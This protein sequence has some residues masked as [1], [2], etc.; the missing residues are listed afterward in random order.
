MKRDGEN[1]SLWQDVQMPSSKPMNEDKNYDVIIAGAGISGITAGYLLQKSGKKCLIIE[2]DNIGFGTTGGTTAHINTFYDA[3]YD[4]VI[5]DFGEEN[6]QL[7]AQTGPEVINQ[8]KSIIAEHHIDCEF[9]DRDSYIFSLDKDQTKKLDDLFEATQKVGI[10]TERISSNPFPIPFD[11]IIKIKDQAQ[12]HP[13]KYIEA[14]S[15]EFLKMGGTISLGK[16][17]TEVSEKDKMVEVKTDNFTYKTQDFIWATHVIPNMNR[18]NFLAAPYRSYVLAFTLQSDDYPEAQGADMYEP[19]HYYRTQE[20]DGQK[21]IIAGGEDHKTGQEENPE[22]RF[23]NL[24]NYVRQYFDVDKITHRWSSQF[25]T[26]T[27]GLP[28]I[29]KSPG[30]EHIYWA[31]GFDGNGMTFGT[32]SA[33]MISDCIIGKA[34][35]YEKLFN[36]SRLNVKAGIAD[37]LKETADAVFHLIADKFTAEKIENLEQIKNGEGKTVS[38]Q[39]KTLSVYRDESGKLFAVKSSCTHMGGTIGWNKTEKSWDCPCH[40]ARFDIEGK[41]LNGPATVDLEKIELPN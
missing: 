30:D 31:T 2:A 21:Y 34:N 5:A 7:L 19:Y 24:E 33:M 6:A 3:Q 15:E 12:F 29:G 36:P 17:V 9:A 41:V 25:Y 18:M 1:R 35:K 4:Q 14:V 40:G 26:P 32:L 28:F 23:E 39:G 8:I 13:T 20:I 11:T 10:P 22:E 27:D 38:L 37:T 16:K